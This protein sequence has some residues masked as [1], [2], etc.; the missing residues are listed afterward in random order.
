MKH[1]DFDLL[2]RK[3]LLKCDMEYEVIII[4]KA[5]TPVERLKKEKEA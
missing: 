1:P 5:E 3:A 4:N 2:G